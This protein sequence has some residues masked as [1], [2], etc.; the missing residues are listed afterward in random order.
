M[1]IF[2]RVC[3]LLNA[4]GARY[5][6]CGGF[7]VILH[8]VPRATRD[9]DLLIMDA[10]ENFRRVLDALGKL[11]DGAAKE[12]T[13]QD[14]K[15]NLVVK[16][17]DEVEVDVSRRA[18]V[19]TYDEAIAIPRI[20]GFDSQ[21][22]DVSRQG[23]RRYS[24]TP[25]TVTGSPRSQEFSGG[26]REGRMSGMASPPEEVS[27]LTSAATSSTPSAAQHSRARRRALR[28][29]TMVRRS[30]GFRRG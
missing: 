9:V 21:Q 15:D 22:A 6:I 12:L 26:G 2:S 10:P 24:D 1:T 3:Q 8:A 29:S 30:C 20:E 17:L 13:P 18:W 16:I 11:A 28:S 5:L 4:E 7:A 19:V 27:L 14:L 25:G 23:S